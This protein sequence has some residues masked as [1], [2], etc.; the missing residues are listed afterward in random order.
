MLTDKQLRVLNIIEDYIKKEGFSPTLEEIQHEI[1]AK[2]VRSVVQYL[3]ALEKKGF[4]RR[5]SGH[6]SIKLGTDVGFQLMLNIPILGVAN[7]GKPLAFA[8][9]K[10]GG[11][12]PVSKTLVPGRAKDYFVLRVDG[13]SMNAFEIGGKTLEDGCY[14]LVDGSQKSVDPAGAYLVI[15]DDCATIKKIRRDGEL[16]Y[17]LPVSNDPVHKPIVLSVHDDIQVNG[18]VAA[19][20]DFRP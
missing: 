19:A 20:F 6:R 5:G 13:T 14:V 2:S 3:D 1:D 7:A 15:V 11:F 12:L 18:R 9:E 8:H 17:L 16:V 10:D 4:I